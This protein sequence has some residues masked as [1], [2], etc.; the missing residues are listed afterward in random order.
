M[1]LLFGLFHLWFLIPI[2]QY[3]LFKHIDDREVSDD[4][5]V[6]FSFPEGVCYNVTISSVKSE[7]NQ[8]TGDITIDMDRQPWDGEE[9][10]RII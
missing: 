10:D 7:H 9:Y 4:M 3:K 6:R 1:K 2:R 5:K 8:V